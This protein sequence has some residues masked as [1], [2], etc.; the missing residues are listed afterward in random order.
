VVPDVP[1]MGTNYLPG[2]EAKFL[3]RDGCG[4]EGAQYSAGHR[5]AEQGGSIAGPPI[6]RLSRGFAEGLVSTVLPGSPS[7]FRKVIRDGKTRSGSK[8]RAGASGARGSERARARA[9]DCGLPS[10]VRAGI[11]PFGRK[12]V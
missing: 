2:Y 11:P 6:E 9:G 3:V 5:A 10:A 8:G 12:A 7:E 4:R 1:A